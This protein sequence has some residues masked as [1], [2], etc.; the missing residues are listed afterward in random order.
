MYV[1]LLLK[2]KRT[3]VVVQLYQAEQKMVE[4]RQTLCFENS[5]HGM[6]G[7]WHDQIA[8]GKM[9]NTSQKNVTDAYI[10]SSVIIFPFCGT[11]TKL[12]QTAFYYQ[13]FYTRFVVNVGFCNRLV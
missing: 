1:K 2:T 7:L 3:A 5:K 13:S 8:C 9:S 11:K 6:I 4:T 12:P 10:E